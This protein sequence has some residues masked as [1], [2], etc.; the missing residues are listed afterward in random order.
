[1]GLG[2][3]HGGGGGLGWGGGAGGVRV[4]LM[5]WVHGG[6]AGGGTWVCYWHT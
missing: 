6:V 1:M 3:E 2:W 4:E 5:R